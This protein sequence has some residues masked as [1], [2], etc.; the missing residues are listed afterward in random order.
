MPENRLHIVAFTIPYP[1]NYGGVIDVYYKL[2]AL[3]SLGV[4]VILHCFAYNR[5]EAAQLETLCEQVHYYPRKQSIKTHL[6]TKPYIV[7]SR[8]SDALLARLC[9]DNLPILFEGLHC[10]YYL[11]HPKLKGRKLIYRESNIE[12]HYYWALAKAEKVPF[13]K[14]FFTLESLKL[15]FFQDKL[16]HAS[17]MLAVS[18]ADAHYLQQH[19]P[20]NIVHYLPSF[21]GNQMENNAVGQGDYA[22]FHGNLSVPENEIAALFLI[23]EV[24][25][26]LKFPLVVAG[27]DPTERLAQAAASNNQVRLIPSPLRDEMSNLVRNARIHVLYTFQATGLK[28]KLLN[29]LYQGG[30]VIANEAMTAGTGLSSLCIM[31]NSADEIREKIREYSGRSFSGTDRT[32][33]QTLLKK[34]YDDILNAQRLSQIIFG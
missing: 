1:A 21:H 7:A 10:C 25:K 22:L 20:S 26:G 18:E 28:L 29:V 14:L 16:C 34:R 11:S 31:A 6:S 15:K 24:C 23:R 8:Q 13:K 3:H 9:S 33:R 19:F 17:H 12:H 32:Q 27:L 2:K 4:R 30:W 5:P